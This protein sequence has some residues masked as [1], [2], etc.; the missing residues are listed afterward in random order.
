[1][2]E[3]EKALQVAKSLI[4][5]EGSILDTKYSASHHKVAIMYKEHVIELIG[6][7][8]K[9]IKYLDEKIPLSTNEYK[10]IYSIF[11]EELSK[12]KAK[13]AEKFGNLEKLIEAEKSKKVF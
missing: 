6:D 1:M 5:F 7:D 2:I 4:E 8:L 3:K 9:F 11:C 13:T 12:R 10:Q